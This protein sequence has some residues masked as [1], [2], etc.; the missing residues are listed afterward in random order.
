MATRSQTSGSMTLTG[1]KSGSAQA[2][3]GV[4]LPNIQTLTIDLLSGVLRVRYGNSQYAEFDYTQQLTL[5]DTISSL[6]STLSAT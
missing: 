5:V 1:G 6:V 3:A 2:V 4:T